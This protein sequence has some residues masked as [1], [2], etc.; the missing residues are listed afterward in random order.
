MFT[1]RT[2]PETK[3]EYTKE[4]VPKVFISPEAIAKMQTY[5][6]ECDDEIGWLGT[7]H[8]DGLNYVISDVFL[9]D[10]EVHSTTTEISPEGLATFAE[11]LLERE[12]GVD[13]WNQMKVWGHSHVN[14]GVSPS[15]QDNKQIETFAGCGVDFFIRII[16]NKKGD[17]KVDLYLFDLGIS[18]IDAPWQKSLSEEELRL[19]VQIN[20]LQE[21]IDKL[22]Q[23]KV[24]N[25][26][27]LVSDEIKSKVK[28]KSLANIGYGN[29]WSSPK[30]Y[31]NPKGETPQTSF[32]YDDYDNG[33][34]GGYWSNYYGRIEPDLKTV[35]EKKKE[36]EINEFGDLFSYF[37]IEEVEMFAGLTLKEVKEYLED[38]LFQGLFTDEDAKNILRYS[39][40]YA[41][42]I[43]EVVIK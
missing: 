26:K 33:V 28:K 35:G 22:N 7:A 41:S 39:I 9:F 3:V 11:A 15:G 10:Q 4:R 36:N 40:E 6:Q 42:E 23:A 27:T 31:L 30:S 21:A 13:V 12:D 17:L 16:A 5:V 32:S 38:G 25:V 18:Y 43:K 29:T 20:M 34:Y 37:A 19:Q 1:Q 8:Q 14:M 2:N 24:D